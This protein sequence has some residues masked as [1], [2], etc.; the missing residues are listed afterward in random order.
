MKTPGLPRALLV[1]GGLALAVAAGIGTAGSFGGGGNLWG[2]Q[3]DTGKD[4]SEA[5]SG[6]AV[7]RAP[8]IRATIDSL[9]DEL[10]TALEENDFGTVA[11]VYA[12]DAVYFPAMA[13][14]VRG[15]EA[16]RS[17]LEAVASSVEVLQYRGRDV[18]V[19]SPEWA[20]EHG[21]VVV[22]TE[23]GGDGG[24]TELSYS[25]LYRKT[26]TGWKIT[27]DVGSANRPPRTQ[28]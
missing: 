18:Q 14:P 3:Y 16:I 13:P 9:H 1:V 15:R 19:L 20:T 6:P 25:L 17:K 8:A 5:G 11:E 2:D 23:A 4:S 10:R 12:E 7:L 24:G 21:T 22:R 26:D 28:R 27:R